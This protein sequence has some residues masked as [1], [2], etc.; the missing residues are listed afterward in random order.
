MVDRTFVAFVG[1]CVHGIS[2]SSQFRR[3]GELRAKVVDVQVGG[4]GTGG[5]SAVEDHVGLIQT[6]VLEQIVHERIEQPSASVEYR[7]VPPAGFIAHP[8]WLA[9]VARPARS[10]AILGVDDGVVSKGGVQGDRLDATTVSR[11]R[12]FVTEGRSQWGEAPIEAVGIGAAPSSALVKDEEFAA[13]GSSD[14]GAA[15]VVATWRSIEAHGPL[16][17]R[18]VGQQNELKSGLMAGCFVPC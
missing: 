2:K 16:G 5:T 11:Y 3:R 6:L 13:V 1:K 8:N 17:C 9:D 14:E 15:E 10:V 7:L 12:G 4:E 18:R